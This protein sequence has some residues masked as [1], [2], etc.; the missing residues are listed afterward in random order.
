MVLLSK[1][2][3]Q[4]NILYSSESP[5]IRIKVD[6][7]FTYLG[8]LNFILYDVALVEQHHFVITDPNQDVVRLLWLQNFHNE[9][10]IVRRFC[11]NT[12]RS[13]LRE[14]FLKS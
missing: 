4:N 9:H 10:R 1:R 12:E 13:I 14:I 3:V 6:A 5:V 7:S 8:N 11:N 2:S